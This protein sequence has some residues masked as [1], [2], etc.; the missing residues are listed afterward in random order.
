MTFE[1]VETLERFLE[2]E[3]EWD[4]LEW[5]SPG[6]VFQN[7]RFLRS[8]LETAARHTNVRPAV[9]LYREDGVLRAIF[10]GCVTR[11]MGIP[12]LTWLGGLYIVD[13]GDV[14]FDNSADM[15]LVDFIGG[16]LE[17]LRK[18]LGFHVCFLNNV[19]EDA[20]I[21][22]YLQRHFRPYRE[23]VAPYIHL[24]GDFTQY[25]D[26]LKVFRK[27]MKRDTLRQIRRLSALGT[28]QFRVVGHDEP[29][30]NDVV[31]AFLDQK[32]R[33]FRETDDVGVT[34]LPGYDEFLFFEARENPYVHI[35]YLAL[36]GEIIA[37]HFG[38]LYRNER[39]YWYMPTY[40]GQYAA[41][42]PGRVLI[43]YLLEDC[44]A[45]GVGVFDFSIGAEQ[46]KY[47]W[48]G[49]EVHLKSFVRNGAFASVFGYLLRAT[50]PLSLAR[51]LPSAIRQ[52]MSH[53]RKASTKPTEAA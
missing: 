37:V 22:P 5:R 21:F 51:R 45:N 53:I 27:N 44:F 52:Q 23:E 47:E 1:Y 26:S 12:N 46:Y 6:H 36:N 25:V 43:Y 20:L 28:L 42:S 29:A 10:S 41:Y 13:Y 35:S 4:E 48:T 24:S 18:R 38:Y 3:R 39:M 31:T 19:R 8:W 14:V 17:L 9:V 34:L 49:D 33:R 2:L 50:D 16:A 15:P 40:D 32:E 11:R 30:L 7:Y